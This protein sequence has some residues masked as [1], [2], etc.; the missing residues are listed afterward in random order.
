MNLK[1]KTSIPLVILQSWLIF[2]CGDPV[3]KKQTDYR[4][5]NVLL[6]TA[7]DLN[8]NSVGVYGCTVPDI[9]PNLDKLAREGMRF[10][11]AFV[12]IAVCQ[13]SRQSIMTGRYPHTNGALAFDPI[14]KAVPTLQEQLTRAGY[15]NGILGKE[16]HLKPTEKFNWD[17]YIREGDLSSGLGIGRDPDL[18]YQHALEFFNKSKKEDKPFFLM[19]NSHDPHR[20]FADSEQEKRIWGEDLPVFTRKITPEEVTVPAFLPDLPEVRLEIAEYYTSVYRLDQTVGA[21]MSALED[22]GLGDN[23]LVMFISD[24]GMA[25]PF[26]KS[27]CYLNSNKTPWIVNWPGVIPE[28]KVDSTHFISGID[29]MPTVLHA[30]HLPV[31]PDMDGTSFLPVLQGKT[32]Q[33]RTRVFTEFHRIFAGIDYS[34]RCVQEGDYGYIVNFWSDGEHK[35][36]GDAAS[37]RTYSAMVDAA[38]QDESVAERLKM[39]EYRVPEELYDF[40]KDPD[41]L[42]NLMADPAYQEIADGLKARLLREMKRTDDHLAG[43]FEEGFL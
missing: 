20:P 23:T 30:L 34:M 4:P 17:Y 1:L 5:T 6:I 2:S 24:N 22:S 16:I 7:D 14:D 10:T 13:P 11:N 35:I 42:H 9:T 37:G 27:N 3:E 39:Y 29:Y 12:N 21:I 36:R 41:G 33:N 28:G 31:V 43:D 19:A 15:L 25:L 38:P 8:Y 40:S 26:A 32:Q 18:Y